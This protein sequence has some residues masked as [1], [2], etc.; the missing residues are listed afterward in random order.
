MRTFHSWKHLLLLTTLMLLLVAKP[1]VIGFEVHPQW[2]DVTYSLVVAAAIVLLSTTV[3]RR[4]TT[5]AIGFPT[6]AAIWTGH[7][8]AAPFHDAAIAMG[9]TARILF[10]AY[11]A[12][13][14][15]KGILRSSVVSIDSIFGAVCAYLLIGVAW[16]TAYSFVESVRPGSFKADDATLAAIGDER[17]RSQILIYY[18]F[19]TLTTVGYGDI[20]PASPAA[21]TLTWL[22][23]MTGQFYIGVLVAALVG[24]HVS[25][26]AARKVVA[27]QES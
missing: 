11:A 2:F 26:G 10:L 27:P 3:K 24:L 20:T 15:L 9:N 6:L 8:V 18:S 21:R 12:G 14:I 7:L 1:L 23:A 17:S 19:V 22:E 4:M 16:G 5:L 25:Q 13:A